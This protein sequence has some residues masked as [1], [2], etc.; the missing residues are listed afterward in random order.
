MANIIRLLLLAGTVYLGVLGYNKDQEPSP[1]PV[2]PVDRLELVLE[3]ETETFPGTPTIALQAILRDLDSIM[4]GQPDDALQLARAY[5]HW[6]I[7]MSHSQTIGDLVQFDK[8]RVLALQDMFKTAPL[9]GNY[10]GQI[11][12]VLQRAYETGVTNEVKTGESIDTS[13]NPRARK[14]V[15]DYL[16]ACSWKFSQIWLSEVQKAS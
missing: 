13:M 15:I 8:V 12:K 7:L 10:Q 14:A 4:V 3:T 6:A 9:K 16:N 1:A 2:G 11:D 5:K